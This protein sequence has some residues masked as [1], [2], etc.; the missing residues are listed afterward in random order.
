MKFIGY[1]TLAIFIL[2]LLKVPSVVQFVQEF[3]IVIATVENYALDVVLNLKE[4]HWF[5]WICLPLILF[6][7]MLPERE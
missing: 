4:R 2:Y 7:L 6:I 1:V 5:I 3:I